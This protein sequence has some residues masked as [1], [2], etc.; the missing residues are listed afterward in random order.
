MAKIPVGNLADKVAEWHDGKRVTGE[1]LQC[2]HRINSLILL[3]FVVVWQ[4]LQRFA[5]APNG[6]TQCKKIVSQILLID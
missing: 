6:G 2:V 5:E 4:T 3:F 1:T